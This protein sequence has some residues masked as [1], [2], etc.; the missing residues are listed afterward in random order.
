[1]S[2]DKTDTIKKE[3]KV[4]WF[5]PAFIVKK[6]TVDERGVRIIQEA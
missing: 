1:M 6:S 3:Q 4:L 5:E 2:E